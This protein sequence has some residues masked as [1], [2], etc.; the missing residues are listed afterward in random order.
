M[1]DE[2]W[3][4]KSERLIKKEPSKEEGK[5]LKQAEGTRKTSKKKKMGRRK[6]KEKKRLESDK[7]GRK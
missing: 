4:K 7:Q 3:T 1:K 2:G 6:E 5:N